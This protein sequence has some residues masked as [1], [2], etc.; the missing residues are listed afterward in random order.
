MKFEN[1]L[2]NIQDIQNHF[3]VFMTGV[4]VCILAFTALFFCLVVLAQRQ[5]RKELSQQKPAP[6]SFDLQIN[7]TKLWEEDLAK[8][9]ITVN[10][11]AASL[12]ALATY[13]NFSKSRELGG[14]IT[15]VGDKLLQCYLIDKKKEDT[16]LH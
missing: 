3:D 7:D 10:E 15:S 12:H 14:F 5:R 9:G 4:A 2:R 6:L 13:P 1:F 11:Y 16:V 8:A